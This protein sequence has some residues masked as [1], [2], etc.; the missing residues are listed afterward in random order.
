MV[1]MLQIM[2]LTPTRQL[3]RRFWAIW[4][5]LGSPDSQ[6]CQRWHPTSSTFLPA[7]KAHACLTLC[8]NLKKHTGDELVIR[9]EIVLCEARLGLATANRLLSWAVCI[10]KV[11]FLFAV[12]LC[13]LMSAS[14]RWSWGPRKYSIA[15]KT[16][17]IVQLGR[18]SSTQRKQ[19]QTR[20]ERTPS[21]ARFLDLSVRGHR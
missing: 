3:E 2:H 6:G 15:I 11:L 8:Q 19:L 16:L 5:D 17:C 14:W 7:L 20:R 13:L 12:L 18:V 10:P 21:I 9:V 4:S 1:M